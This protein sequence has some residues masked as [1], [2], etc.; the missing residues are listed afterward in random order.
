MSTKH[1]GKEMLMENI[2]NMNYVMS[3]LRTSA[4]PHGD[5]TREVTPT[6]ERTRVAL[7]IRVSSADQIK[8]SSM[9]VQADRLKQHCKENYYLFRIYREEGESG[10][11]TDRLEFQ[12]MLRDAEMKKFEMILV[13]KIDRLCRNIRDLV[14][15]YT[16]LDEA[17]VGIKSLSE[18]IDTTHPMGKYFLYQLGLFAEM[19]RDWFR[20]RSRKGREARWKEGKWHGGPP[21]F[22][23]DYN[24]GSGM[25]SVNETEADVVRQIFVKYLEHRSLDQVVNYL[26]EEGIATRN[27]GKWAQSTVRGILSRE[28]YIGKQKQGEYEHFYEDLIIVDEEMFEEAQR[29]LQDRKKYSPREMYPKT[30]ADTMFCHQCGRMVHESMRYCCHCGG[31]LANIGNMTLT[32]TSLLEPC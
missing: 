14:D 27:G 2:P 24:S 1:E 7:Y 13:D 11:S 9:D 26:K 18:P 22:G 17:G 3:H 5:D 31:G 30:Y 25:L 32:R 12:R 28:T 16:D 19:E 4:R 20:E 8:N 29:I 23:Y 6:T 21:P 15:V 10:Y